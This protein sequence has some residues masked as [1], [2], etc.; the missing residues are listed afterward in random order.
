MKETIKNWIYFWLIALVALAGVIGIA[1]G[2]I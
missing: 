1:S 2:G